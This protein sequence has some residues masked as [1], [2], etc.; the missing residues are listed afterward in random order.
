MTEVAPGIGE[1]KKGLVLGTVALTLGATVTKPLRFEGNRLELNVD[2]GAVG[3]AQ[4]GFEDDEGRPIPGYALDDC[5]YVNG[6]FL[7][8]TVEWRDKGTD[9]S[10]LAG[11][12]VRLVIEMRGARLYALQFVRE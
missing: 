5:V 12:V 4:V 10:A 1:T 7:A 11:R 8:A 6:D 9:V 2:T 3:Y